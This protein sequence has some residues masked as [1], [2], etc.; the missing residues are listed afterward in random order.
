[1]KIDDQLFEHVLL[2][3][4][5]TDEQYLA[6]VIDHL[7]PEHLK[8]LDIRRTYKIITEF[9]SEHT[10]LPTSTEIKTRCT[11]DELKESVRAAVSYIKSVDKTYNKDELYKNTEQ[12]IKERAVYSTL[13]EVVDDGSNGTLDSSVLLSKFE[14]A[15]NINLNIDIG[16]DYFTD[17]DRHVDDMHREESHI[18]SGWEWIDKKLNGGFIEGGRALYVFAGE[19][20]VGKSIF[21]GNIATNICKQGKKVL[22]ISLEMPEMLYSKRLSS[23]IAQV[24]INELHMNTD[25]LKET[26]KSF[27]SS[28]DGSKLI[29]KEF[30]PSTIT[31]QQLAGFINKVSQ[32]VMKPDA[33]VLDYINLLKGSI[34]TN[35]YDQIKKITEQVRALSYKFECPIITATQLNR[36]GYNEVD[37]G[38]D[39][40]GESYG[41]GATADCVISIFQRDEDAELNIINLGMMK[42]RFGPNFG[43]T[44]MRIDYSTLTITEEDISNSTEELSDSFNMLNVLQDD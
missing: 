18:S 30:P 39:T 4:V 19:T 17:I 41:M 31:P 12:Y 28:H 8:D 35:S 34:G 26:L 36:S 13:M 24:P 44:S 43:T 29:V 32:T 10:Q 16:V 1:V 37:P 23:N 9:Y 3:N 11:D 2:F 33:I 25:F 5:M 14:T 42:N 38:L 20:N 21:L 27:K 15:C 22:L 7:K 6:S 40:V